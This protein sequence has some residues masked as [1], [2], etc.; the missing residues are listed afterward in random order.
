MRIPREK[1]KSNQLYVIYND[2][3]RLFKIGI[4]NCFR[5][6]IT[7]LSNACGVKLFIVFVVQYQQYAGPIEWRLHREYSSF[8]RLGEWFSIPEEWIEDIKFKSGGMTLIEF[9]KRTQLGS[10]VR[11]VCLFTPTKNYD[12]FNKSKWY[13]NLLAER[14]YKSDNLKCA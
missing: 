11:S 7:D 5:K 2:Q 8:R 14:E 9:R 6:R 4:T 1:E 12:L 10:H 3:T 13:M